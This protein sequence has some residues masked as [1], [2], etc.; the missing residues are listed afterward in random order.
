[1]ATEIKKYLDTTAL[2][3]LVEQI[4][5][6][7]AKVLAAAKKYT[8]D[9]GALY[10]TAGAAATAES[11]AKAYTD[12]L[13]N[14][15]VK[16][17]KEAIATLNGDANTAGSVAKAIAD[18]KVVIDG[19]I[20][21][22]DAKADKNAQDIAAI[23]NETTGILAQAKGYTDTEVAKVQGE[24]DALETYV[25]TIPEG[26]TATDVIGYVQERTSGI[27]TES[28]L[29]E[30]QAAVAQAQKDIDAVEADYLKAA[31]KTEI[32]GK[33]TAVETAVNTEKSRAEGKEAELAASI[34][35]I[36]DDYLKAADK[37]ELQGNID[38]VAGAVERLTNGVSA[39]EID[40]VN[41][42]IAYV[43]AHGATVTGLQDGID[44]NAEAIEGV[45][46]RMTTAEGKITA[47]EQAS[48]THATQTAL[49]E[50]V[51]ALEG[52]DSALSGRITTLENK[53]TG[54]GSVEDMIADAK[55]EAIDAAA[56]AADTKD[57]AVLAAA[58]KY[59]DDEDALIEARVATLETASATHAL[60][61]DLTALTGRVSTA[62][63]EIDT[64]QSEMDAVEA[65]AAANESAIGQLQTA[66]NGK[67]AQG[68]FDDAVARVAVNE[69][70]IKTLQEASATHA[71][72]SDLT[73]AVERIAA[74]ETAIANNKSAIE[75]FVA[76]TSDEVNALF[77]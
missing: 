44:A 31:D 18:A 43:N 46:G 53:F 15:Q 8:D 55:Q 69:G 4:K 42:L 70:A 51:Q 38:T 47:L 23:N 39:D 16:T 77:A 60:A 48:A 58:K 27:A 63:G 62:E 75:S 72:A 1:M 22:V 26:A 67:V 64:L 76:I 71:L 59:A 19:D 12:E 11:N 33:I 2:G 40:G 37:T 20:D 41:D 61:S 25:G 17:N 6:E 5:S 57:E 34:K 30:L 50:A 32:E 36:S 24:V 56:S 45:A 10:D 14:G 3:T 21:A 9:A 7:D 66:V 74:N 49:A 68:D 29:S 73:A 52:A 28:A 13:A 65:K 35:A 54:E